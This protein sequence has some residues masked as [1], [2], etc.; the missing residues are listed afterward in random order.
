M[1]HYAIARRATLVGEEI[2]PILGM[3]DAALINGQRNSVNVNRE[4]LAGEFDFK[5][6]AGSTLPETHAKRAQE[7]MSDFGFMAQ[8]PQL[9]NLQEGAAAFWRARGKNPAQ[10]MLN[11]NQLQQTNAGAP[12]PEGSGADTT[13]LANLLAVM[14]QN[15]SV[16]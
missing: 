14:G 8:T 10:Y 5:I 7:A 16:Q 13:Q 12:T 4:T 1:R 3:A 11:V 9:H 6:R 2:V 15:G